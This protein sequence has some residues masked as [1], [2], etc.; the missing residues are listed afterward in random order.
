MRVLLLIHILTWTMFQLNL[1]QGR[2][3][4]LYGFTCSK[5]TPSVFLCL[6]ELKKTFSKSGSW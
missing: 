4:D 5:P 6:D 3:I 1:G 2:V